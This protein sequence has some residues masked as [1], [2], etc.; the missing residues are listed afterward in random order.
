LTIPPENLA[1]GLT[2]R[3]QVVTR[4]GGGRLTGVCGMRNGAGTRPL[5]SSG[6]SGCGCRPRGGLPAATGSGRSRG[7]CALPRGRCGGGTGLGRPAGMRRCGRRGRCR[8]SGWA[9][10]SGPDLSWSWGRGR[11]RTGFAGDQ[12]W[13]VGRIKTLIG[14]WHLVPAQAVDRQLRRRRPERPDP[15][16]QAQAEEDPVPAHLING[17]LTAT[18]LTIESWYEFNLVKRRRRPRHRM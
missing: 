10:S 14:R 13:T 15:H 3:A 17:C 9:R 12:R 8:G 4:A 2:R 11:W 7:T 5:S 1:P 18:G 16:R 6:G